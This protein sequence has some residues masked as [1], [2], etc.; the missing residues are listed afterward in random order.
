M[1]PKTRNA[2]SRATSFRH[3]AVLSLTA[4]LLRKLPNDAAEP[5]FLKNL[6]LVCCFKQ[7]SSTPNNLTKRVKSIWEPCKTLCLTYR[8]ANWNSWFFTE[9]YWRQECRHGNNTEAVNLFLLLEINTAAI[10][11]IYSLFSS[12]MSIFA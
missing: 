6:F 9:R 10:F 12:A 1:S 7:E 8:A 5:V 2:Q 11:W 3:S 4:T